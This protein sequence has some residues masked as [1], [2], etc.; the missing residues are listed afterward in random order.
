[1]TLEAMTRTTQQNST[2]VD[3]TIQ[4]EGSGEEDAEFE[5]APVRPPLKRAAS[6]QPTHLHGI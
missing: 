5:E 6:K 4:A 3:D 1:M 2:Q